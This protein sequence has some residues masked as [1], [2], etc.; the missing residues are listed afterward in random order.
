MDLAARADV[1]MHARADLKQDL[2]NFAFL[3]RS[4]RVGTASDWVWYNVPHGPKKQLDSFFAGQRCIRQ[5]KEQA[6]GGGRLAMHAR[7][8]DHALTCCM[9]DIELVCMRRSLRLPWS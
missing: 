9:I 4:A 8:Q 7:R 5:G 2:H 1:C 6:R 3:G